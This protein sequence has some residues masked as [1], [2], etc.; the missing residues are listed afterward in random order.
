MQ[1]ETESWLNSNTAEGQK[2]KITM[3]VWCTATKLS[4]AY[5]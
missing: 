1:P 4:K 3:N 2:V 5:Y